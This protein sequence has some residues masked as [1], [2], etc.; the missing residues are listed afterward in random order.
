MS[1]QSEHQSEH[2]RKEFCK[3][4][5]AMIKTRGCQ[6]LSLVLVQAKTAEL[7]RQLEKI[8][9]YINAFVDAT[10]KVENM[11]DD[12]ASV[13]DSRTIQNALDLLTMIQETRHDTV[14]NAAGTMVEYMKP[15]KR[16]SMLESLRRW[17]K[18]RAEIRKRQLRLIEDDVRDYILDDIEPTVIGN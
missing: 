6:W 11:I 10:K 15:I 2:F 14:R 5:T 13:D 12:E 7:D 8:Q 3:K 17:R 18:Q 1:E 16:D 9:D 4:K